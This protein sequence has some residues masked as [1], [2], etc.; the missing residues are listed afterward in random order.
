MD[1][2]DVVH[3]RNAVVELGES[4][5]QLVDVDVLRP[6]HGGEFL[7]DELVVRG[8]SGGR[9]RPVIDQYPVGEKAA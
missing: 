1:L 6:I 4:T 7:Q 8:V 9:V 5:K 3:R 2:R